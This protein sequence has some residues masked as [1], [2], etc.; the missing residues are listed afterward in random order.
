M[1]WGILRVC[2]DTA[3]NW[4]VKLKTEKYCSKIIFKY[5]NSIVGPIF[6]KK[7]TEK[8]NLWVR[9]QCMVCTV[10][11]KKSNIATQQWMNSKK[12]PETR[13]KKKKIKKKK[14][15]RVENA[16]RAFGK[17]KCASQTHTKYT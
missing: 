12:R 17:R 15:R 6:N 11:G 2:L 3:E 7:V 10:H 16:K 14:R 9:E 13:A 5:V 1:N 8:C 4:K